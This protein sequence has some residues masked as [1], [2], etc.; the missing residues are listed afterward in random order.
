MVVADGGKTQQPV[1]RWW[2]YFCWKTNAPALILHLLK[3]YIIKD[4]WQQL[5]R[6][7]KCLFSFWVTPALKKLG[8]FFITKSFLLEYQFWCFLMKLLKTRE[9][10]SGPQK[11]FLDPCPLGTLWNPK[12]CSGTLKSP[13]GPLETFWD[14]QERKELLGTLKGPLGTLGDP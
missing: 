6:S 5:P 3:N 8:W 12:E 14:I 9:D 4:H 1:P 10:L 2:L 11:A 7:L 13:L